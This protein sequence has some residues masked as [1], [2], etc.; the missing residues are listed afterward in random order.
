M[1]HFG[2]ECD[3][4]AAF[5]CSSARGVGI[6]RPWR[7]AGMQ[8]TVLLERC[9]GTVAFR[10]TV[11]LRLQWR[12][13]EA[14]VRIRAMR[15]LRGWHVATWAMKWGIWIGIF[16][17]ANSVA[18][19]RTVLPFDS[20][21]RFLRGD[22]LRGEAV[23]FDDSRWRVLDV[24]HDWGIDGPFDAK[25]PAGGAGA[26]LPAGVGW[27]RKHFTIPADAREPLVFLDFDAVMANA[28]FWVDGF[29]LGLK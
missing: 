27:Y 7:G 2:E 25:A 29:H 19:W 16:G 6:F 13:R 3:L 9:S 21:W 20:Q 5:I 14:E 10:G 4:P 23:G 17:A 18:L 24:P 12:E 22:C 26:F 8:S 15:W 28:D 1:G 11:P